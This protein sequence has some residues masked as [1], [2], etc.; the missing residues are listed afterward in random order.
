MVASLPPHGLQ[1]ERLRLVQRRAG[2]LPEGAD[3]L[4]LVLPGEGRGSP[5]LG[6]VLACPA[7]LPGQL[8]PR[9]GRGGTVRRGWGGSSSPSSPPSP[10]LLTV[11][12]SL[13]LPA[14]VPVDS[15][16][17]GAAQF[18]PVQAVQLAVDVAVAAAAELSDVKPGVRQAVEYLGAR[19][20]PAGAR[21]EY[22]KNIKYFRNINMKIFPTWS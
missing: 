1:T 16:H 12:V 9:W 6:R 22:F 15:P 8:R 4:V 18:L 7:F 21:P 19:A 11:L 17:R 14:E 20:G 10:A 5:G 3:R 2:R 13:S